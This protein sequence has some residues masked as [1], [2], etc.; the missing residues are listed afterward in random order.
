ML[1]SARNFR[2]EECKGCN[3]RMT[4]DLH[5]RNGDVIDVVGRR[6]LRGVDV[7]VSDGR[8]LAVGRELG[9]SGATT[10]I[11]LDGAIVTP[12]LVDMHTHVF[13]GGGFYGLDPD[14][15]AWRSGVTTWV[16]AGSAGAYT[17][18]ALLEGA[19]RRSVRVRAM[20]NVSGI[21]LAGES[22]E[23][24]VMENLRVDHAAQS[25][26]DHPGV[27]VGIKARIDHNTVGDNGLEPLRRAA[28]LARDVD[29]PLMVHIGAAPPAVPEILDLLRGGD[30]VT[31]C[32]TGVAEGLLTPQ[33]AVSDAVREAYSRGVVLDVGHGVGGFSFD[34]MEAL[35]E[36]DCVPHTVS[37]DLHAMSMRRVAFDLP[38][39]MT[40]MLALGMDLADVVAAAT[41]V[42][43]EVLGLDD[44]VGT[45]EVGAPADIAVFD[46]RPGPVVLSDA[47]GELRTAPYRLV[48]RHTFVG[49]RELLP[50]TGQDRATAQPS[51]ADLAVRG[52]Y[53]RTRGG[54]KP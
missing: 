43:A 54:G 15:V 33:G 17:L 52:A 41:R 26:R 40:K 20:L 29:L 25:V 3:D 51:D 13:T 21:G 8:I 44:G 9:L 1:D 23:C 39:V 16:D 28:T 36:V 31:H 48:N 47:Y 32:A 34:V 50:P 37:S 38:T 49:G 7:A 12:G 30:I 46:R 2:N 27:V 4:V 42:P 45:L 24:R 14:E 53:P 5:L 19:T 10:T 6:V 35:L 11:D 18:G 22:Y